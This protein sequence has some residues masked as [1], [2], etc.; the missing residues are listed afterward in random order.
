MPTGYVIE[1]KKKK[2]KRGFLGRLVHEGWKDAQDWTTGFFPGMYHLGEVAWSDLQ[3]N[4][5]A[6]LSP[7]L[8]AGDISSGK[9]RLFNEVAKPYAK[10]LQKEFRHPLADPLFTAM[11]LFS[12]LSLGAGAAGRTSAALGRTGKLARAS[13]ARGKARTYHVDGKDVKTG[14][15]SRNTLSA[16]TQMALDNL[17]ERYP[18]KFILGR[19]LKGKMV[20]GKFYTAGKIERELAKSERLLT[21]YTSK[22]V[23]RQPREINPFGYAID[24]INNASKLSILYLKPAYFIPN[25]LGNVGLTLIQHH[26]NPIELAKS[27]KMALALDKTSR[28][29]ATE[30]MGEGAAMVMDANQGML[31][32]ATHAAARVW[33]MGMD[34]PFRL[35]ALMYELRKEGIRTPREVKMIFNNP[36][37]QSKLSTAARRGND[38][39]IDYGDLSKFERT[40]I[41][42]V[43]FFYPWIKGSTM[44]TGR[45]LRDHPLNAAIY[46]KISDNGAE[47]NENEWGPVPPFFQGTFRTAGGSEEIPLVS[48]PRAVSLFMSPLDL[49][50]SFQAMG[51]PNAPMSETF[52]NMMT[53]ALRAAGAALFR[54][55]PFTGR[56][57]EG[58]PQWEIF[59]RQLYEGTPQNLLY[60][61]LTASDR[62]KQRSLYPY[63]DRDAWMQY[64]LGGLWPHPV[65]RRILESKVARENR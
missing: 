9:S 61:R 64:L 35:A 21:Q 26:F 12:I 38:A 63:S 3:R 11:D 33:S 10:Q 1:T 2:H 19:P 50:Q 22:P 28:K 52:A 62:E 39:L 45:Y 53:P 59:G 57:L 60:K 24:S 13:R 5:T 44:Y 27:A 46:G 58:I 25:F 6:F 54:R 56:S 36:K 7:A 37:M 30:I 4:P 47:I 8:L 23:K 43:L 20:G 34:T 51:D 32:G 15:Y 42:R 29:R 65:N 16:A 31:T 18:H 40:Y 55:D 17:R 49:A 14:Y 41:S 48:N